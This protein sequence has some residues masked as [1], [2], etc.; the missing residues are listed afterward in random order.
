MTYQQA[1]DT[2][3]SLLTF[4]I[5][6]GLERITELVQR[7]GSPD[8]KLKFVHIAGTNG[9]G[10]VS[11]LLANTLTKA[12]YKTGL[13]IS[14]YVLEFRERFQID[15]QMIPQEELIEAVEKIDPLVQQMKTEGKI[16]TEFEFV[17]AIALTWYAKQ[18]CDI[19]V[20]ETGLGGRFDAT[21]IIRTPLVS[22]ITS[23]SLDHTAILG[24]TYEEIAA[25]KCGIIKDNAAVVAYGEQKDGVLDVIRQYADQR[26]SPLYIA[27]IDSVRQLRSD[28]NGSDFEF[29]DDILGTLR[30]HIPLIGE[31]QLKNASTALYTIGVLRKCGLVISNS[32]IKE[33]FDTVFFP[34]RLELLRKAPVVLL[35]GAHNPGGAA[36]LAAAVRDHL[37]GKKLTAVTGMLADKDIDTVLS[38][39][40]PLFD[41]V[42][43]VK[44]HNPRALGA[45]NLAEKIQ[46][47]GVHAIPI[48]D[49]REAYRKAL[50]ITDREGAIVIFG[51]L[52]LASDMRTVCMD[53]FSLPQ[54][55]I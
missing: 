36:A 17:F 8:Q 25:E 15:G 51:S 31:H 5:K 13:F 4:G 44:P 34:A 30:L 33:G 43:T 11:A 39:L 52:Y 23:I 35:D 12:G 2:I 16:I 3:N 32:A 22:V 24:E 9:K 45:E 19:V 18:Q 53:T 29:F 6:P 41:N 27:P 49:D 26:H 14:P 55:E 21:N 10:S 47:Y 38:L 7:L 1:I 46:H 28:L 20:L 40:I 37:A 54:D 42:I 48:K 50:E